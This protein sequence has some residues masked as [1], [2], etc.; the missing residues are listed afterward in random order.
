MDFAIPILSAMAAECVTHPVLTLRAKYM[1]GDSSLLTLLKTSRGYYSGISW[2]LFGAA[3]KFPCRYIVYNLLGGD[4]DGLELYQRMVI[5]SLTG[6]ITTPM[7]HPPY[8]VKSYY[9]KYNSSKELKIQL[10]KNGFKALFRGSSKTIVRS[11]IG[12]TIFLPLNSYLKEKLEYMETKSKIIV[13]AF[14]SG[15]VGSLALHPIEYMQLRHTLGQSYWTSNIANYYRGVG[16]T[17]LRLVPHYV[18]TMY[19]ISLG[20]E[21]WKNVKKRNNIQDK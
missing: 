16:L 9:Q 14:V 17:L 13:S 18:I 21:W 12:N 1:S 15:V 10:K 19:L 8:A 3:I 2:G 5:G 20:E 11:T 6:I 4:N 7:T